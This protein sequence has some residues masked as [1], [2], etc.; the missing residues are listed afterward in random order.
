LSS[1]LPMNHDTWTQSI[2]HPS[3]HPSIHLSM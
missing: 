3:V 1:A 2:I